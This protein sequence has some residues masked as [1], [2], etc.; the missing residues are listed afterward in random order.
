ML[1][2]NSR[3]RALKTKWSPI[4]NKYFESKFPGH[5]KFKDILAGAT[6]FHNHKNGVNP[7]AWSN[8]EVGGDN[9]SKWIEIVGRVDAPQAP[10]KDSSVAVI[11][12]KGK[13]PLFGTIYHPEK[14]MEFGDA[15]QTFTG[16]GSNRKELANLIFGPQP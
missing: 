16:T 14:I 8:R 4:C 7:A 1:T 5:A 15:K 13:F 3:W 9:L 11:Q 6:T 2:P 12:G 10:Y